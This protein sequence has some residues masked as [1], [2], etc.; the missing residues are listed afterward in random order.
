MLIEP[1]IEPGVRAAA[2]RGAVAVPV[3]SRRHLR[4]PDIRP[5]GA[6]FFSFLLLS[7]LQ[8]SDATIDLP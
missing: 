5:P 1:P 2:V 8:L 6:F 7:S 3:V 4:P